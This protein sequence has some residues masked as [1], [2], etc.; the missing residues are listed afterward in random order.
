MD[1][2]DDLLPTLYL[3]CQIHDGMGA[4]AN[5]A[6][7]D[8]ISVLEELHTKVRHRLRWYMSKGTGSPM[9][10]AVDGL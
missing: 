8:D 7:A 10:L 2:A 3:G 5:C 4:I 6:V 1:F 9:L